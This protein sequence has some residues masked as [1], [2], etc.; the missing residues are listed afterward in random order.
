MEEKENNN[1]EENTDIQIEEKGRYYTSLTLFSRASKDLR[2]TLSQIIG[3]ADIAKLELDNPDKVK[4]YLEQIIASGENLNKIIGDLLD[5]QDIEESGIILRPEKTDLI[6]LLEIVEAELSRMAEERGLHFSISIG[7]DVPREVIADRYRLEQV[8]VKMVENTFRYTGNGGTVQMACAV[9]GRR[10]NQVRVEFLIAD[11]SLGVDTGYLSSIFEP[12]YKG[13]EDDSIG[14]GLAL[15]KKNLAAMGGK[16]EAASSED[17]GTRVVIRLTLHVPAMRQTSYIKRA[18]VPQEEYHFKGGRILLV[19]DH[20]LS[21]EIGCKMLES[22]GFKVIT[23]MNGQEAVDAY[24]DNIGDFDLILMDI[25]MPVMDGL[26]AARA[27]RESGIAGASDIP[28]VAMTASA[29]EEDILRSYEAGMNNHLIKPF[30]PIDVY[31]VLAK[32]LEKV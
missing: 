15:A 3:L 9:S 28:I 24:I 17:G 27:I 10:K 12:P 19:D 30:G 1:S 29:F 18:P 14:L 16:V 11:N 23:A 21:I 8:L 7:S 25:R 13:A 2:T 31:R 6:D 20:M 22:A 4:E 26:A 5:L 32:Y